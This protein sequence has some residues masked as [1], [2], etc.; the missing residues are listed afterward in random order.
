[1]LCIDK[2]EIDV[3]NPYVD[4][5]INKKT[6]VKQPRLSESQAEEYD[7]EYDEEEDEKESNG[8]PEVKFEDE[9]LDKLGLTK[10]GYKKI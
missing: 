5:G 10:S 8:S 7:E 6:S 2:E 3:E 1:M 9:E 4:Q